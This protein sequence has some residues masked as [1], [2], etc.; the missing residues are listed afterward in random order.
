MFKAENK[1]WP[2]GSRGLEHRESFEYTGRSSDFLS[3]SMADKINLLADGGV[4]PGS[5]SCC[6]ASPENP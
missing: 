4:G 3:T 5:S 2:Q 1:G 6:S